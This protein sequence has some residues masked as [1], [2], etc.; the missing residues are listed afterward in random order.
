MFTT[1]EPPSTVLQNQPLPLSLPRLLL[2][3]PQKPLDRRASS[4]HLAVSPLFLYLILPPTRPHSPRLHDQLT[5]LQSQGRAASPLAAASTNSARSP[6][7]K[8]DARPPVHSFVGVRSLSSS[9]AV[10]VSRRPSREWCRGSKSSRQWEPPANSTCLLLCSPVKRPRTIQ[11]GV[12]SPEEI[13]AISVCKVEYPET[14][15]EGSQR[16]VSR[17][18]LSSQP[19]PAGRA[20]RRGLAALQVKFSA[21]TSIALQQKPGGLSDPR[22]GTIDR[23][24][25]CATCGEGM[26]ECPGHFGHIELSRAVFHIGTLAVPHQ[27]HSEPR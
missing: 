4:P 17:S 12:L 22:L 24:F 2:L 8:Q 13:K 27:I 10:A 18:L 7:L 15:E 3:P 11:F 1:R 6:R 16:P 14:Y 23:N 5:P 21:L 19:Q 9:T 20:H 26:A 25:K